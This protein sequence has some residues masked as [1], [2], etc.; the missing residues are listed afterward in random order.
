MTNRELEAALDKSLF[1][2]ET[3]VNVYYTEYISDAFTVL[4]EMHG[5]GWFWRLDSVHD[6][7]I[8]TMQNLARKTFSVRSATAAQAIC[9]CAFRALE[10]NNG[11]P[12][13]VD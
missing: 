10:E 4:N 5:R 2:K 7:V 1:N 6:G 9:E 13:K 3:S 11:S 12:K 8:C